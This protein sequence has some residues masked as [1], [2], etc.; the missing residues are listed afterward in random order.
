MS[1]DEIRIAPDQVASA[2]SMVT[3]EA[4]EAR[5]AI[6]PLFDSAEPAAVGNRGFATGPKLVAFSDSVR[7][8]FVSTIDELEATGNKIVTAA[9]SHQATEVDNAEGISRVATALNGLGRLGT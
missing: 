3:T 8:D 6:A 9:Q 4:A 7:S 1:G 5:A 2:G